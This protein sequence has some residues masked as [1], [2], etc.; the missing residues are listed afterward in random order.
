MYYAS[1]CCE[2]STYT[3]STYNPNASFRPLLFKSRYGASPKLQTRSP[4][5]GSL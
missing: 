3:K 5:L 1:T 4:A 2:T